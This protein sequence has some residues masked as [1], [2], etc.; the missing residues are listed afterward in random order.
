MQLYRSVKTSYY[1]KYIYFTRYDPSTGVFTVPSG[2]EGYYY[3]STHFVVWGFK[4]A[5]IDVQ[6]N[7]VAVCTAYENNQDDYNGNAGCSA[8]VPYLSEGIVVSRKTFVAS[9]TIL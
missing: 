7:G 3:I 1:V 4:Y 8:T 6:V 2:G 9:I 5:F